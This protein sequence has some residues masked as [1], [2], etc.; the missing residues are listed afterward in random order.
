MTRNETVVGS[1]CVTVVEITHAVETMK[2]TK[3]T[4][5]ACKKGRVKQDYKK[6][7]K[8]SIRKVIMVNLCHINKFS[9][10]NQSVKSLYR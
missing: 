4:Q 9:C 7:K 3:I 2:K 6:I 5:G 8:D 1:W 10:F